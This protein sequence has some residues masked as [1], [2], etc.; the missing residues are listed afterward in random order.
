MS[1]NIIPLIATASLTLLTACGGGGDSGTKPQPTPKPLAITTSS[2]TLNTNELESASADI[3]LSNANGTVTASNNYAGTGSVSTKVNGNKIEV[4]YTAPDTENN[5]EESFTISVSDADETKSLTFTANVINSS[6]DELVSDIS[7]VKT[8]IAQQDYFTEISNIFTSYNKLAMLTSVYNQSMAKSFNVQFNDALTF[9]KT[10]ITEN[11][12]N[13]ESIQ[14]A[15]DSYNA[16][17]LTETELSVTFNNAIALFNEKN[18]PLLTSVNN[19]ANLSDKLPELPEL[20]YQ[21]NGSLSAFIG[22]NNYGEWVDSIWQ[23]KAEFSI[24]ES[25][26]T[27]TCL[28]Q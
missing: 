5:T 19:I 1:K 8:A 13:P 27:S 21:V 3:S 18:L 11:E 25:V 24:I 9:A 15:I 22:N 6:G 10:S 23:Y 2:S 12:I 17:T 16:N 7:Q 4:L 14:I 20:N 26:L 28:A